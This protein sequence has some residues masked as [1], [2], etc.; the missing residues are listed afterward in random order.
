MNIM[1]ARSISGSGAAITLVPMTAEAFAIYLER[2]IRAFA[3]DKVASG[4]WSP[5]TSLALSRRGFAELLPDGLATP[6]NFLFTL[7]DPVDQ[8]NVGMLWYA[9]QERAGHDIAYVYDVLVEPACRRKGYAACA[10]RALEVEFG[11]RGLAGIALHV[12]GHNQV[13]QAFYAR[14]GYEATNINLFKKVSKAGT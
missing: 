14:L 11:S 9:L 4:Q 5:E 8:A 7:Q 10:F 13:A 1:V 6:N 2:A 12:F 3:L